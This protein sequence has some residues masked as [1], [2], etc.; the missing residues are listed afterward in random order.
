MPVGFGE[1]AE[2][3]S[4]VEVKSDENSLAHALVIAVARVANDP[5]YKAYIHGR[6]ILP[7]IRELLQASGVDTRTTNIFNATCHNIG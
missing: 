4:I 7:Q 2:K 6:K 3:R 5:D 1:R